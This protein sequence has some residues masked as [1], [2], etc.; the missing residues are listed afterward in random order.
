MHLSRKK[1]AAIA[2]FL[3]A[4]FAISLI[5][6]PAANGVLMPARDTYAFVTANPDPVGVGQEVLVVMWLSEPLP[7]DA[8]RRSGYQLVITKPDGTTETLPTSGTFTAESTGSTFTTYTPNE[9]GTYYFQLNFL[10]EWLNYTGPHPISRLPGTWEIYYKP[11]TSSKYALVVQEEQIQHLSGSPLPTEYWTRPIYGEN[12]DWYPIAGPWL[13][14]ANGEGYS[15]YGLAG[16][17]THTAAPESPHVMWTRELEFGGIV[18]GAD[19]R[20]YY[21]GL[22][23]ERKYAGIIMQ[24]RLYYSRPS[25]NTYGWYCIDLRTGEELY[26]KNDSR[27]PNLGQILRMETPNQH[28]NIP[29]LWYASG[30]TYSLYDAFTGEWLC[31]VA[32]VPGGATVFGESGELLKYNL[33]T[34]DGQRKLSMWNSSRIAAF[35][36]IAYG[37]SSVRWRI[38]Q[39]QTVD[40]STGMQWVKNV[41]AVPG[42]SMAYQPATN[43]VGEGILLARSQILTETQEVAVHAAY[44]LET[45]NLKWYANRTG[46]AADPNFVNLGA[47]GE[48]IYCE[49]ARETLTWYAYDITDGTLKWT[50]SFTHPWAMYYGCS[51]VAYGK[52]FTSHYDGLHALDVETGNE[53]WNYTIPAGFETPYGVYPIFTFHDGFMVADG[54][55]Y[56][57]TGEHSPNDPLYRGERMHCINATDGTPIWSIAFWGVPPPIAEGYAVTQNIYD[58]RIYCLGK[59][60]SA[61][62]VSIQNDVITYGDSML[63]KGNVLDVSAGAQQK[64]QAAHFPNG[65]AAVSDESMSAWMEYVYMQK[66]FPQNSTGVPVS[67]DVVDANGNYRNIGT[68]TTELT[69]TF[70]LAWEPDIPGMYTIIATFP[71]SKGYG[72]SYAVTYLNVLEAPEATPGPTPTPAS[73]S[74]MY[75]VPS[76]IGIIVAIAVVGVVIVLMLRKRP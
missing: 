73:M 67:I 49:Y 57:C 55:I 62:T 64:E 65:V 75:F 48:G 59:G 27:R 13:Q 36:N 5:T 52:F 18:G 24:G 29:Y 28:G 72:S 39:G 35:N 74:E 25:P 1:T 7:S 37:E 68:T 22:S 23:Y 41:S 6:L 53:V 70:V 10:G 42:I 47:M 63:I 17:N 54:K 19:D 16:I 58:N 30:S 76:V 38:P 26:Y 56:G 33:Y 3:M 20:G 46:L 60:P 71:G 69:G 45:G 4:S 31:D 2:M 40:G 15:S 8:F 11:S 12:R 21:T 66:P 32:N 14:P 43:R 61:T 9:V 50:H 44:D 34:E 51:V